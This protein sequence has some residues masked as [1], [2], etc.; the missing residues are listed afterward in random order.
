MSPRDLVSSDTAPCGL[1]PL[2]CATPSSSPPRPDAAGAS[3][4]PPCIS[5]AAP[6]NFSLTRTDPISMSTVSDN[7]RSIEHRAE[8]ATVQELHLMM[9]QIMKMRTS[10]VLEHRNYAAALLPQPDRLRD[11]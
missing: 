7:L 6:H 10:L 3:P 11:D 9:E 1:A 5:P 8:R 4:S 2:P